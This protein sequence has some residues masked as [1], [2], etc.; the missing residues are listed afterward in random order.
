MKTVNFFNHFNINVYSFEIKTIKYSKMYI[1]IILMLIFASLNCIDGLMLS[2]LRCFEKPQLKSL[3]GRKT[4]ILNNFNKDPNQPLTFRQELLR[5]LPVASFILSACGICFQVFVLYP[6]HE[7]LSKL[8]S[9]QFK[10]KFKQQSYIICIILF[11][12][13]YRCGI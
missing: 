11:T 8:I 13:C 9:S 2:K 3:T 5:I 7:E 4:F 10:F 6:W 12:I 1:L